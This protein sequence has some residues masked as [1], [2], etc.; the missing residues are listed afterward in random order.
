MLAPDRFMESRTPQFWKALSP[1]EVR[2]FGR[3]MDV[4]EP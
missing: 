3:I 4:R 2:V 1:M